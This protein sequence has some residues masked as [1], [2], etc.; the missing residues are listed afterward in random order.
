MSDPRVR[1]IAVMFVVIFALTQHNLV[2]HPMQP[3]H[4]AHGYD[5]TALFFLGAPALVALLDSVLKLSRPLTRYGAL[6]LLLG[7]FL[8]DNA[9]SVSYTHLRKTASRV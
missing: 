5:W 1:L 3:I 8:L 4:F 6:A 9:T 2:M 7:L